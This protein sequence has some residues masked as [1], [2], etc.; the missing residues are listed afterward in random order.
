M[1]CA[2]VS[3]GL[4]LCLVSS[5]TAAFQAGI[6]SCRHHHQKPQV[7][8]PA[9]SVFSWPPSLHFYCSALSKSRIESPSCGSRVPDGF[10]CYKAPSESPGRCRLSSSPCVFSAAG[11]TPSVPVRTPVCLR[12]PVH[13]PLPG[14]IPA[15]LPTHR[16][17]APLGWLS[18]FPGCKSLS[19]SL[20]P[21][22]HDHV[23]VLLLS[24]SR[25][26][27]PPG[28][29]VCVLLICVPG[30]RLLVEWRPWMFAEWTS[31]DRLGRQ[32]EAEHKCPS[33]CESI[34]R[35]EKDQD[36]NCSK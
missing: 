17:S 25:A 5:V 26:R 14:S 32:T 23:C 15:L 24:P 16:L 13:L 22:R 3:P 11:A 34:R 30:A 21:S 36:G 6:L 10:S 28:H 29:G 2:P 31:V 20:S 27:V 19:V 8:L 12:R 35:A 18:S 9:F 7:G 1:P 4:A 33:R